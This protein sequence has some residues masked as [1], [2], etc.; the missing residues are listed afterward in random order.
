MPTAHQQTHQQLAQ[1]A[2]ALRGQQ[3]P[4]HRWP[5]PAGGTRPVWQ[6]GQQGCCALGSC[7]SCSAVALQPLQPAYQSRMSL[8]KG[9]K[10]WFSTRCD[11]SAR[12][13]LTPNQSR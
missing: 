6:Q 13:F 1:A 3:G 11:K 12:S 10:R 8:A 5:A 7:C 9:A 2:E 4:G